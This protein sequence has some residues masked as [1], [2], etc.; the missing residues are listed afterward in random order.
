MPS[1][2]KPSNNGNVLEGSNHGKSWQGKQSKQ[3]SIPPTPHHP[4]SPVQPLTMPPSISSVLCI[5]HNKACPCVR[6]SSLAAGARQ[7]VSS[8]SDR[9]GRAPRSCILHCS[10]SGLHPHPRGK[11][12]IHRV[13]FLLI[14]P[15]AAGRPASTHPMD[16]GTWDS[17][18]LAPGCLCLPA[19]RPSRGLQL[20]SR[21]PSPRVLGRGNTISRR[22]NKGMVGWWED[23]TQQCG[24]GDAGAEI[25]IP[26]RRCRR[27]EE[28]GRF[29]IAPL[30]RIRSDERLLLPDGLAMQNSF[31]KARSTM[32]GMGKESSMCRRRPALAGRGQAAASAG[33]Y[34]T[35]TSTSKTRI[36][37]VGVPRQPAIPEPH[38]IL[39]AARP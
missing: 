2:L 32:V 15:G 36:C 1:L 28:G 12:G 17:P 22:E 33:C 9:T 31:S 39:A 38:M 11:S 37:V 30:S 14:G 5:F 7:P 8:R 10:V 19:G 18:C 3:E 24:E 4:S 29:T 20:H 34:W 26:V 27:G 21:P 25:I 6:P 16:F 13:A 23:G 35:G